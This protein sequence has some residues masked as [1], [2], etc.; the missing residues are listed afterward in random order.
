MAG[1]SNPAAFSGGTGEEDDEALRSRVLAS[2]HSLPNG[3]NAAYYESRVLEQGAAAVTVLPRNRGVGTVDI[4][5]STASGVPTEAEIAAVQELLEREREICVDLQVSAPSTVSV[6]VTAALTIADGYDFQE[7]S[8]AAEAALREFF[9][10]GRLSAPVYRAGL[11]A[12]LMG[13]EGVEN[14]ILSAPAA[15]IQAV[16]GRLPVI[17]SVT[18][19]EAS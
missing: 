4:V 11:Y 5:F 9:G 3:A 10:G 16:S 12:L 15:D 19:S 14:C 13:V 2:Y 1:V 17:G 7:V 6:D 18:L 8:D